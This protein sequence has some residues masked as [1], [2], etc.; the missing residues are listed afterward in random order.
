MVTMINEIDSDDL[1]AIITGK[2]KYRKCPFCNDKGRVFS[3]DDENYF[4]EPKA[5]WSN[6]VDDYCDNCDGLGYVQE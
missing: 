2:V 5:E 1:R 4:T 6:Y 3:I